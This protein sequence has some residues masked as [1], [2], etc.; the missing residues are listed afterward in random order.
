MSKVKV[1]K[2]RFS[3]F[4]KEWREYKTFEI[5]IPQGKQVKIVKDK[6]Y[7]E[8]GIRSHGK[9]L[10][11]KEPISGG[12]I[13]N[14]R[15]F[16]IEPGMFILNI[17]F[18]WE[19]AIGKTTANEKGMIA[20]HRF[21]MYEPIEKKLNLDFITNFFL[22]HVG[23]HKLG[24]ASPGGA[25]RNKTLG[26]KQ[27]DELKIFIPEVVEQKK[28]AKFI[29]IIDSK[30]TT[31]SRKKELINMYTKG[32]MQQ[33]FSQKIR[34]KSKNGGNY[35]DWYD[36]KLKFYLKENKKRNTNSLYKEV[37][38]VA[39]SKG[40]INQLK[41]LGR[42]YASSDISNYKV[43]EPHDIVYTKSPTSDFPYGIIKQNKTG[44]TGVVSV[45]YG[46]FI[47]QNDNIG[48]LLHYYFSSCIKTY[49]YLSPVIHK[50]AKNTINIGN[51]T[52]LNGDKIRLPSSV[53]EQ[54][55]IANFLSIL[56]QKINLVE[57]ELEKAQEFKKGL[58]QQ[59]FV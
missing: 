34:F 22:T 17:V 21:P 7:R 13:G 5:L 59:M 53:E 1:P 28:I 25:G 15:V 26:K 58:L 3:Q 32:V 35:P 54:Y 6:I 33:I 30:I 20:S 55:K 45:L 29:S 49:N 52:F 36:E 42:S 8:I 47:P 48:I 4:F 12:K 11:Y 10:F 27:F 38:S 14:K 2:L 23:K 56:E 51:A 37:F 57:A 43:V 16:W 44:R 41:H 39:K 9:G 24:I 46:V 31:L 50:G 18:A 40:V 19:Q